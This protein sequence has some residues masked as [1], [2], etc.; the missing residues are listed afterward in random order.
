MVKIEIPNFNHTLEVEN[1]YAV[2]KRTWR[3]WT[4]QARYIFNLV[5]LHASDQAM[6]KHPDA[7]MLPWNQWETVRWN[8]GWVA[9]DAAWRSVQ[10]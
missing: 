5:Y 2:P 3:K 4:L 9:A 7:P 8:A 10:P 1:I 6:F